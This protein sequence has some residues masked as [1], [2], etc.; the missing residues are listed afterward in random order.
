VFT[1]ALYLQPAREAYDSDDAPDEMARRVA[2]RCWPA[3]IVVNAPP[4]SGSNISWLAW[5][6]LRQ[7][8]KE[9]DLHGGTAAGHE[10]WALAEIWLR[11]QRTSALIVL[12][13]EALSGRLWRMLARL[14]TSCEITV[15]LVNSTHTLAQSQRRLLHHAGPFERTDPTAFS[16]WAQLQ[17]HEHPAELE[18]TPR[19]FKRF[20]SVPA[21]EVP[22]FRE[23]CRQLL[24]D[25]DFMTVDDAYLEAFRDARAWLADRTEPLLEEDVGE[26]LARLIRT[27]GDLDEKLTRLRGAQA[28]FW[29]DEWHLKVRVNGLVAA[30]S[31]EPVDLDMRQ[32]VRT[33]NGYVAPQIA[34]LGVL[35]L[36]TRLHPARLATFNSNQLVRDCRELDLD[37][38]T[39]V[40]S[41]E[42]SA[43]LR[44]QVLS[45]KRQGHPAD[46]PLF[47]RV[48]GSRMPPNALQQSLRRAAKESGLQ[49]TQ[50]WLPPVHL[51][52]G[53]WMRRRGL[54]IQSFAGR[55][56]GDW[57]TPSE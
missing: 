24:S 48:D 4:D 10:S 30:H 39:L 40:F 56:R 18:V 33:L 54:S 27:A 1:G 42:E 34:A 22:F 50:A 11:A 31:T 44:A 8:G 37:G 14:T 49:L 6:I 2:S 25:Q 38:E 7:L 17:L 36:R 26:F 16:A 47:C 43:L 13:A 46:G 28:G 21:D 3:V 9:H 23:R 51:E 45:M 55:R 41:V 15:L 35:A 29:R 57:L 12:G 52:H 19:P 32:A 20:P 5:G 53:Y